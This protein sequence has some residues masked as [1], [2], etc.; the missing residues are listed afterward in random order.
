MDRFINNYM[1]NKSFGKT[2]PMRMRPTTFRKETET[3]LRDMA[4]VLKLTGQIKNQILDKKEET[5][6]V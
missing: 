4:Y 6:A 3:I 2:P 5:A 1:T